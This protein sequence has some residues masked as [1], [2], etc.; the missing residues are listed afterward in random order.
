MTKFFY[1]I[2]VVGAPTSRISDETMLSSSNLRLVELDK[3]QIAAPSVSHDSAQQGTVQQLKTNEE[4]HRID[5]H[6]PK[7]FSKPIEMAK[8][9]SEV[10]NELEHPSSILNL[11]RIEENL[12]VKDS[13]VKEVLESYKK[14]FTKRPVR[15]KRLCKRRRYQLKETDNSSTD[16]EANEP[17]RFRTFNKKKR[18]RKRESEVPHPKADKEQLF[19]E[20][21]PRKLA[22]REP[23]LTVED[24]TIRPPL[25]NAITDDTLKTLMIAWAMKLDVPKPVIPKVIHPPV[26]ENYTRFAATNVEIPTLRMTSPILNDNVQQNTVACLPHISNQGLDIPTNIVADQKEQEERIDE[27]IAPDKIQV[28]PTFRENFDEEVY[29]ASW[30][31]QNFIMTLQ[32]EQDE[33]EENEQQDDEMEIKNDEFYESVSTKMHQRNQM[34]LKLR[35]LE[36]KKIK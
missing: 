17:H 34:Y 6:I 8:S 18:I 11:V 23:V 9:K 33:V 32:S 5:Q 26:D 35:H 2:I 14:P 12:S 20:P 24:K 16:T 29:N 27:N 13:K 4:N 25:P 10:I 7:K 1:S 36:R 21:A 28:P 31:I 19:N 3:R 15:N 22:K 30:A